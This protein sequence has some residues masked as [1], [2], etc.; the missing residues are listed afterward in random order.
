MSKLRKNIFFAL[1]HLPL[2]AFLFKDLRERDSTFKYKVGLMTLNWLYLNDKQSV[3]S[4]RWGYCKEY[5]GPTVKRYA[6]IIQALK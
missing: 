2:V 6:K 3:L 5:I 1:N 4:G